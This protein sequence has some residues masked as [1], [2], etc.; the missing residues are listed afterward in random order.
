M[1]IAA[2]LILIG[3]VILGLFFVIA[4]VRNFLRFGERSTPETNYGWKLPMPVTALGFAVQIVGGLS[5]LFGFQPA[6]G[7]AALI[8]FLIGATELFHNFLMFKGEA[9][10]PHLYLTLVNITLAGFLLSTIGL[11]M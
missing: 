4:G 2:T 9:R 8:L 5:V 11:A 7:A 6:W 3:R 10:D 1:T